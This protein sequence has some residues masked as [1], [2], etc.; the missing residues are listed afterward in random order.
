MRRAALVLTTLLSF[1]LT[2]LAYAQGRPAG[3]QTAIVETTEAV[4]TV[5]VFGQIVAERESAVAT[6]VGAVRG[7]GPNAARPSA[8]DRVPEGPGRR[9]GGG[10]ERS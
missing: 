7:A 1:A 5:T 6:R 9:S 3:V 4:E 10:H 8:L 2:T